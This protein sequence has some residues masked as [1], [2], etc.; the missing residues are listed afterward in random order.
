MKIEVMS[1]AELK[2]R[3]RRP[4]SEPTAVI[5]IRDSDAP[6]V[7]LQCQPSYIRHLVFDD[8]TPSEYEATDGKMQILFSEHDAEEIAQFVRLHKNDV[9]TIIC[10]CEAGCSRSA[11]VAAAIAEW[12]DG[13]GIRFFTDE[14]YRPNLHV[15]Q[16]IYNKKYM[17]FGNMEWIV[18]AREGGKALL[19]SKDCIEERAFHEKFE[20]VT[21]KDC[22]LR[23]YL[24]GP[25]YETTFS[26]E[27]KAKILTAKVK[28][29]DN[30]DCGTPGENDTEDKVFLLS[31]DEAE[32]Y[33]YS[34]HERIADL[35]NKASDWWLRSPGNYECAVVVNRDGRIWSVGWE[36][37]SKIGGVR[38]ALWIKLDSKLLN[39][40]IV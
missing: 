21:W 23:S 13:N 20:P 4:F 2:K 22:S 12:L 31:V 33:F 3:A 27:E 6:K 32:Q 19:L 8:I 15:F 37:D 9:T 24:N 39:S 40:Q 7:T 35:D 1:R 5:S 34:D 11:A 26:E 36:V 30:E 28:N 17:T 16:T 29:A 38:P 14:R 10:Q 25:W 18:L